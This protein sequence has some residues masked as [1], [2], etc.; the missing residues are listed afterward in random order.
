M[1]ILRLPPSSFPISLPLRP[2][3]Q[4]RFDSLIFRWEPLGRLQAASLTCCT[5]SARTPLN[6]P[7]AASLGSTPSVPLRSTAAEWWASLWRPGWTPC[8]ACR[9][10]WRAGRRGARQ[11]A[12]T[13][14]GTGGWRVGVLDSWA[15]KEWVV[16]GF[17]LR[18]A[19]CPWRGDGDFPKRSCC[20]EGL[21]SGL[22]KRMPGSVDDFQ[23][24]KIR[25]AT[26]LHST[27]FWLGRPT[28]R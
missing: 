8:A 28:T 24:L 11:S 13:G 6:R 17:G 27:S 3:L 4:S 14:R 5:C 10:R 19:R 15:K 21:G 22:K 9:C 20:E 1:D 16:L 12:W 25:E 23:P 26:S 2:T 7:Q 18:V